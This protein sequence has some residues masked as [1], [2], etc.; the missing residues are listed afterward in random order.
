MIVY[1][2]FGHN[3]DYDNEDHGWINNIFLTEDKAD[4]M[5]KHL[6]EE[7]SDC[8]WRKI[9]W[10]TDEKLNIRGDTIEDLMSGK[11]K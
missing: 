3:P 5:V 6:T 11:V 10:D 2:V 7:N 9:K 1:V 4:F 8:E